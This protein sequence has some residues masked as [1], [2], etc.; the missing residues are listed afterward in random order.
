MVPTSTPSW[1]PAARVQSVDFRSN[2][3]RPFRSSAT[4]SSNITAVPSGATSHRRT[5]GVV[6]VTERL[7]PYEEAERLALGFARSRVRIG[8]R[9]SGAGMVEVLVDD[10]GPGVEVDQA[11]AIFEP[12]RTSAG[13]LGVGLGLAIAR[14]I[15]RSV[16]GD[17]SITPDGALTRFVILLP[18]S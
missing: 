14:R 7:G 1:C 12:G 11:N 9:A 18:R 4:F 13:G 2:D 5:T 10:D 6:V 3:V 15:A 16:G 17:V 8:S